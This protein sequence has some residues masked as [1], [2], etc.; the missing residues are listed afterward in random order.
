MGCS[1]CHENR[2]SN[3]RMTTKTKKSPSG[4]GSLLSE[5][6]Q[7]ALDEF[8]KATGFELFETII[9]API[10]AKKGGKMYELKSYTLKF[11]EKE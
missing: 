4:F 1:M 9:E 10:F 7:N 5:K 2:P 3:G 6:A 11:Y 8:V